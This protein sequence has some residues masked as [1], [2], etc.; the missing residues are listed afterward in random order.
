[1]LLTSTSEYSKQITEQEVQLSIVNS[2]EKY[3]FDNTNTK[4]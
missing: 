2:L 3:L 4:G 1:M